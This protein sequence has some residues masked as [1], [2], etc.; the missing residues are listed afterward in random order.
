MAFNPAQNP[1]LN[2]FQGGQM[3]DLPPYP[4][5]NPV[6]LSGLIEIVSPG[7]AAAGVNYAMSL[8]QLALVVGQGGLATFVT[9]GSVYN[10][11]ASDV[12]I[13][14]NKSAGSPTTINLLGAAQ[15][16]QPILIKDIKGD[17][18]TNNITVNFSGT[19]DGI[20]SPLTIS[21]N[22]GWFWMNPLASGNW[23]DAS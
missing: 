20:A 9:S 1:L 12:R 10:S 14:V 4:I 21:S 23:Y 3:T 22:Y 18:G 15:Y 7:T 16:F 13:L 19:F 11:I 17:A 8:S 2:D 5:S 6:D